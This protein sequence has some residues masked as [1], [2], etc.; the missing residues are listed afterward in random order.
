MIMIMLTIMHIV[1][2]SNRVRRAALIRSIPDAR[3]GGAS[4]SNRGKQGTKRTRLQIAPPG[5]TLHSSSQRKDV[6]PLGAA[7]G[8]RAS[9]HGKLAPPP[10]PIR[11][12]EVG[13]PS[14]LFEPRRQ[15][16]QHA[17]RAL[18]KFYGP[19]QEEAPPG[20][21]AGGRNRQR[22]RGSNRRG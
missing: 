4:S 15:Q 13:P 14:A 1:M 2:P 17:G 12:A 8:P 16:S 20:R 19:Y 22:D 7:L 9:S 6:V 3:R 5:K 10:M 21:K 11:A 18:D